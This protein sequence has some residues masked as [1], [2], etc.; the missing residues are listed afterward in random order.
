MPVCRF[1]LLCGLT[2][3]GSRSKGEEDEEE[4]EDEGQDEEDGDS[5]GKNFS[6]SK[7]KGKDG[8]KPKPDSPTKGSSFD[9]ELQTRKAERSWTQSMESV[10][11]DIS[12]LSSDMVNGLAEFRRNPAEA[13]EFTA[14]MLLVQK[15]Q[16]WLGAVL[17]KED[18]TLSSKISEANEAVD[19]DAITTSRDVSALTRAGPCPGFEKLT[20][21]ASLSSRAS[22]FR[23]C[24]S[25]DE[26]KSKFESLQSERKQLAVLMASCKTALNEMIAARKRLQVI[27]EKQK[28][29]EIKEATKD[30]KRVSAAAA[31][32][33]FFML[34]S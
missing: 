2:E 20:T 24:V 5:K 26:I 11:Q 32:S 3:P 9:A 1:G 23:T 21:V 17:E 7:D 25:Q 14:E 33:L 18:A 13:R 6:P 16:E 10:E 30:K 8:K 29:K 22:E 15:R 27:K 19:G 34:A 31:G 28:E 4:E 12:K